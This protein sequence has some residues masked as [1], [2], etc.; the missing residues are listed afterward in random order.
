VF[1][2]RLVFRD[3]QCI[4]YQQKPLR[5]GGTSPFYQSSASAVLWGSEQRFKHG[6]Q[7]FGAFNGKMVTIVV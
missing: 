4:G 3:S 7:Q 1:V 5:Q 6:E 2:C